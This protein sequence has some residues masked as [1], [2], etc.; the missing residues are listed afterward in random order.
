MC[1]TRAL[2]LRASADVARELR[3]CRASHCG[4]NTAL[5]CR[6]S[7]LGARA[8]LPR[9][10]WN[11]PK[12]GVEPVSPALA[13]GFLS[14]APP[15]KSQRP[16]LGPVL[17]RVL[18]GHWGS[19]CS[20]VGLSPSGGLQAR[21]GSF[22]LKGDC[23]CTACTLVGGQGEEEDRPSRGKGL[24]SSSPSPGTHALCLLTEHFLEHSVDL[25]SALTEGT[26][27][28]R[29]SVPVLRLFR[30]LDYTS[31]PSPDPV[32]ILPVEYHLLQEG[33]PGCLLPPLEM[34]SAHRLL[35][36][37]YNGLSWSVSPAP[38]LACSGD[39][40]PPS[41]GRSFKPGWTQTC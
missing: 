11:L 12:P 7:S 4:G 32:W 2:G 25:I 3:S 38:H 15:G 40:I 18:G 39:T 26:R 36:A 23:L 10:R 41:S 28:P 19:W 30:H 13:A 31:V 1:R 35:R 9:G 20:L 16:F 29:A 24:P 6:P 8:W 17:C 22:V 14:T 34:T 37:L 21:G 33:L 27:H 5:E